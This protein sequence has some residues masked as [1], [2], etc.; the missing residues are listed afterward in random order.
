GRHHP[1]H[2]VVGGET[3][4]PTLWERLTAVDG[5]HPVN[6]YGPTET[7]VDAYYWLPGDFA[8]RPEGRPVR[9]S[10]AYVLDSSL[11]PVPTGVTGELY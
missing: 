9:G 5:V 3:V 6:L 2:L 10:R 7:T 11:R 4:P 1:A 8:D